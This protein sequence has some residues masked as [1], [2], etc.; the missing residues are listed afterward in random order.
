MYICIGGWCVYEASG[1]TYMSM[2]GIYFY[3]SN[4]THH[5]ALYFML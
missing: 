1:I 3:A 2:G 5:A 4:A